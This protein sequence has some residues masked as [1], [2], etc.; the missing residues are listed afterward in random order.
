MYDPNM[1][2]RRVSTRRDGFDRGSSL[3]GWCTLSGTFSAE[4]F[5]RL[6]FDYVCIDRQHGLMSE[7]DMTACIALLD[8][9]AVSLVV[10]VSSGGAAEIGRALDAG[11]DGIIVPMVESAVEASAAANACRY[12][13]RGSRSFGPIRPIMARGTASHSEIDGPVRCI[14][15]VE[16]AAGV[17]QADKIAATPGVDGIYIGP[18][19]L[20]IALGLEPATAARERSFVD[21]V[22][23]TIAAGRRAGRTVGMHCADAQGARDALARGF[24]FATACVDSGLLQAAAG[25]QAQIARS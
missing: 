18:G 10:R 19:D 11:A 1:R 6:G 13:P 21:A 17:E 12:A 3:G 2:D 7:A 23:H 8:A 15:M 4:L 25:A 16:S 24:D 5:A 14:V 22:E 20:A 9:L